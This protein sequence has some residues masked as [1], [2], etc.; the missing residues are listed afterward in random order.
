MARINIPPLTRSLLLLLVGLTAL[1]ALLHPATKFSLFL[2]FATVHP[3]LGIQ[4]TQSFKFPWTFVTATFVERN[5]WGLITTSL[6]LFFGGR[7]LERAYGLMEIA[8]FIAVVCAIP[9]LLTWL[10]FVLF[11]GYVTRMQLE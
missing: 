8:K 5:V 3:L 2:W 9:N 6:T 7:Y 11:K 4:P 10:I 1:N